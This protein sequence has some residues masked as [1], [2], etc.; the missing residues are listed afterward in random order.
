MQCATCD[1]RREDSIPLAKLYAHS[2]ILSIIQL[3]FEE[4]NIIQTRM[5]DFAPMKPNVEAWNV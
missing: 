4:E 1:K 2:F 3:T 5:T